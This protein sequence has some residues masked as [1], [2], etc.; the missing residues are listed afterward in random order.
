M[1]IRWTSAATKDLQQIAD[2]L[3]EKTPNNAARFIREIYSVPASL[4]RFPKS[5]RI[6]KKLGTR[7][8]VMSSLPYV[9]VYQ[10]KPDTLIV[11]RVLHGAQDWPR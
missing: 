10:E 4:A 11:V 8:W 9:V 5:G 7:E 2:Y 1:R 6:G 3:F